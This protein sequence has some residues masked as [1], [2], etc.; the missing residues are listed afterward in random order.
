[1]YT[2]QGKNREHFSDTE[3]PRQTAKVAYPLFDMLFVTLCTII[4]GARA[5]VIFRNRLKVIMTGF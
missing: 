4:A 2:H 3:D 5:G 1:M